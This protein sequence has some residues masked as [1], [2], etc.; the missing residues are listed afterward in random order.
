MRDFLSRRKF[1]HWLIG[2]IKTAEP[3]SAVFVCD[4][5]S[6]YILI[7]RLIAFEHGYFILSDKKK[8]LIGILIQIIYKKDFRH[9]LVINVNIISFG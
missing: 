2:Y 7:K 5:C 8:S 3:R 4:F 6:E 9:I 1:F